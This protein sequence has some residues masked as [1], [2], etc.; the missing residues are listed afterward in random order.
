VAESAVERLSLQ[1]LHVIANE[2]IDVHDGGVSG[3]VLGGTI[4]FAPDDTPRCVEEPGVT[5]L[6]RRWGLWLRTC[7]QEQVPGKFT[8]S[9][10]WINP[11][12]LMNREDPK[13][14]IISSIIAQGGISSKYSGAAIVDASHRLVIEGKQGDGQ[15]FM[16]GQAGAEKL[17]E[18]V[19]EDVRAIYTRAE[20]ALGPVRFEWVH[21]G[22]RT[23]VV[24]LH[25]GATRSTETVIVPGEPSQWIRFDLEQGLEALR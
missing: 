13:G 5:S 16:R 14:K 8:T 21:D 23:W 22:D 2:T 1:G 24:Q 19:V 18:Q 20:H 6:P 7:P 3:V 12:A 17:A 4:E 11:S 25:L 10:G 9:R 15:Q